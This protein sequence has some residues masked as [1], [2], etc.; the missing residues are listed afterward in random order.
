MPQRKKDVHRKEERETCSGGG[1]YPEPLNPRK[2]MGKGP[3]VL[4]LGP[5]EKKKGQKG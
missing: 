4:S 1:A 3:R 5:A 2:K